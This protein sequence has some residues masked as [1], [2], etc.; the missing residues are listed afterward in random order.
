[1]P[2]SLAKHGLLFF[3]H[4][5]LPQL[6]FVEL[7]GKLVQQVWSCL[8]SPSFHVQVWTQIERSW[9][10]FM[11]PVFLASGS[12]TGMA[13][14]LGRVGRK[15]QFG[16]WQGAALAGIARC[17]NRAVRSKTALSPEHLLL[18]QPGTFRTWLQCLTWLLTEPLLAPSA[19]TAFPVCCHV[20]CC[21]VPSVQSSTKQSIKDLL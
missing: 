14:H 1:M 18:L 19:G 5:S 9:L 15:R 6:K 3:S 4:T 7:I 16:G 12:L 11:G 8:F 20:Y 2:R 21:N 10:P 17:S 13:K